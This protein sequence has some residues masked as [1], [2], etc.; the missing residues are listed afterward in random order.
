MLFTSGSA[1]HPKGVQLSWQNIEAASEAICASLD[2]H[3]VKQQWLLLNLHYSFGLLGQ[4]LPAIRMGA[5]TQRA[6]HILEVVRALGDGELNGMISGVPSQLLTLCQLIERSQ[7][8]AAGVTHVV[9][10]GAAVSA[11]LRRQLCDVFPSATI[12]VNYGQTEASPRILCLNSNDENFHSDATG[13]PV[14]NLKTNISEEG[15]LLVAGD[16]IM[17]GYLGDVPSPVIDGWLHTGDTASQAPSGLVTIIGRKDVVVNVGGEKVALANVEAAIN[18]LPGVTCGMVCPVANEHYGNALYAVLVFDAAP[19]SY[20]GLVKLLGEV[21]ASHC[22][23]SRFYQAQA[24]PTNANGKLDR[25][26][27]NAYFQ[28]AQRII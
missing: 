26:K 7:K 28:A 16:Q 13:Y 12:Y 6:D 17:L 2:F 5:Q 18:A 10:A 1:G 15:E 25:S 27:A 8:K 4:L 22:I 20:A 3:A 11:S 23:P 14:G 24:L 9:S 21:V 19:L